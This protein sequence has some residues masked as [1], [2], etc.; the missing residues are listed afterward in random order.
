MLDRISD[1][2]SGH[3]PEDSSSGRPKHDIIGLGRDGA[4]SED[5]PDQGGAG[6]E[7]AAAER[8]AEPQALKRD[9]DAPATPSPPGATEDDQAEATD[10]QPDEAGGG[11]RGALRKHPF[12]IGIAAL[13]LIAAIVGGVFWYLHARNYE[14]TDDAFIDGR[15]VSISPEVTGNIVEVPV[16]DNQVVKAGA[17][18]A[19]IDDRDYVASVNQ[20]QAGIEQAEATVENYN[21]QIKAQ[22][23]QVDQADQQVAQAQAALNFSQDENK[24]YQE[25]V[26]TGYGTVQRAQQAASDL[27]SKQAALGGSQAAQIAA[28]KQIKV[29]KAQRRNAIAQLD[30]AKAQKATA[31]AN[32]SRTQLHATMD[33]RITRLTAAVGQVATQSQAL[34]VLVPLD[35]WVTA[36]FKETQL[37]NIRI[38][39]PVSIEIDAYGRS[40]PGHVDSIQSGSGTAFSLLP[41]ENAT[42][43]YVKVVQRIP[44]KI[45]FDRRPDVELGPGMSVVPTVTVRG[46]EA[47]LDKQAPP[48]IDSAPRDTAPAQGGAAQ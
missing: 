48:T 19:R 27:Q 45:T 24:R 14:T 11:F 41:A 4:R 31:D 16:T 46:A 9:R 5:A 17:L 2:D 28:E 22:Q 44:V 36:N 35:V 29:L 37:A 23:A 1:Q 43:N 21:S 25:L 12:A 40:Y 7:G 15:P 38:G 33:G 10:D 30:S 26:K 20:A 39:Q 42:G 6:R 8:L 47:A 18:L 13:I 32:L 3:E 34:M